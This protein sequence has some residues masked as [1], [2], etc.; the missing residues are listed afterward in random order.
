[1][2]IGQFILDHSLGI[3]VV[4]TIVSTCS[5]VLAIIIF[6]V[7]S[8]QS[9]ELQS[10]NERISANVEEVHSL[11]AKIGDNV[12]CVHT[13][14]QRIDEHVLGTITG[15]ESVM[16][17]LE[18]LLKS[19]NYGDHAKVYVMAYWLWFGVDAAFPTT[20]L[21][22]IKGNASS[23]YR[24]LCARI[25][26][27]RTITLVLYQNRKAIHDFV[28]ALFN[29]KA[30]SGTTVDPVQIDALVDRYMEQIEW[31]KKEAL[32]RSSTFTLKFRDEIPAIMFAVESDEST[33]LY[34][35][36]ETAMLREKAALGGFT[37]RSPAMVGM[38]VNQIRHFAS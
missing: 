34:Y 17:K 9:E 20:P 3:G 11:S 30:Q 28:S 15:F 12:T 22:K 25:S 1:M 36:G 4:G 10:L 7:Q 2:D 37:S 16:A 23:I 21:D 27:D 13:L 5:L 35:I 19:A 33:G 32:S 38:L 26:G 31:L 18:H 14:S 24:E 8:Q 6:R 29:F